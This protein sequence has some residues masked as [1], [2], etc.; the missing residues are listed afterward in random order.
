MRR[1]AAVAFVFAMALMPSGARAQDAPAAVSIKNHLYNPSPVTITEG[2]TVAWTN[3]D[4]DSHSV[5]ADDGS[6]DSSPNCT[7]VQTDV[8]CIGPDQSFQQTFTTAGTVG[9]H[10]RVVSGMAGTVV[11]EAATTTTESSTTTSSTTTSTTAST[12]PTSSTDTTLP[13]SGSD[14]LPNVTQ[15][16]PPN[17]GAPTTG[18]QRQIS[19]RAKDDSSETPLALVAVGI[20]GATLISGIVLVR[21]GRVP[22]G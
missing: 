6:F 17:I 2:G 12:V 3:D 10:C 9:Y 13:A 7:T 18:A 22:F 4:P 20:G 1:L 14:Q 21:K 5:T 16:Q 8:T 11:V 19:V 15:G